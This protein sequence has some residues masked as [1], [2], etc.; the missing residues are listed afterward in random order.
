MICVQKIY[1]AIN[2]HKKRTT[3]VSAGNGPLLFGSKISQQDKII[4]SSVRLYDILIKE[5]NSQKLMISFYYFK[6]KN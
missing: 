2:F 5:K 1:Q 6:E 4:H 3:S